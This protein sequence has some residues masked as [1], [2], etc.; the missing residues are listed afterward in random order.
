MVAASLS[1]PLP[2]ARLEA[3][4]AASKRASPMVVTSLTFADVPSSRFRRRP[5]QQTT[6]GPIA[7]SFRPLGLPPFGPRSPESQTTQGA[8]RW[9]PLDPHP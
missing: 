7:L 8:S 3:H 1:C 5:A 6:G 2:R 9:P 4:S